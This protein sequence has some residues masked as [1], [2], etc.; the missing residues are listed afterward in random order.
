MSLVEQIMQLF[1][2]CSREE[3]AEVCR[4]ITAENRGG[5]S[6]GLGMPG[7]SGSTTCGPDDTVGRSLRP[8]LRSKD[9]E[10]D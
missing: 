9:E 8:H 5:V 2:A 6:L 3:R 4:L 7:I 10:S 1:R